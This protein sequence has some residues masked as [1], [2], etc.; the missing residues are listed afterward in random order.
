MSRCQAEGSGACDEVGSACSCRA[1]S[2]AHARRAS[3][4]PGPCR[5]DRLESLGREFVDGL[6]R[7]SSGGQQRSCNLECVRQIR[8]WLWT[9]KLDSSTPAVQLT[10]GD[11]SFNSRAAISGDRLAW[12][13]GLSRPQLITQD[14]STGVPSEQLSPSDSWAVSAAVSGDRVAWL[15][16]VGDDYQVFTQD[17]AAGTPA[18]QITSDAHDH[19]GLVLSN[20]R[21]GWLADS[22][23]ASTGYQFSRRTS[24]TIL[25]RYS[26]Q[27][28]GRSRR[29]NSPAT[30][31]S[32]PRQA[33]ATHRSP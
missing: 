32:G 12:S 2:R 17:L 14:L 24:I 21:L 22:S 29:S 31:S 7:R 20:N 10:F 1:F 28:Q 33:T 15:Q 5:A 9:R 16:L 18:V 27:G 8:P 25:R 13:L 3:G 19:K 4:E 30:S 23:D 6:W 11:Y 26:S